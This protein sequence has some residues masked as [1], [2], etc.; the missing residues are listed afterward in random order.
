MGAPWAGRHGERPDG[1]A[2]GHTCIA[3]A[4]SLLLQ[5]G[6]PEDLA[7]SFGRPAGSLCG[8]VDRHATQSVGTQ[9]PFCCSAGSS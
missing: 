7:R 8:L 5:V 2:S 9:G 3:D 6:P 1:V 4:G